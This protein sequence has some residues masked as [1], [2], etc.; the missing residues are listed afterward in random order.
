MNAETFKA[1]CQSFITAV[2]E[3]KLEEA[4]ALAFAHNYHP[5]MIHYVDEEDNFP[6]WLAVGNSSQAMVEFLVKECKCDVNQVMMKEQKQNVLHLACREGDTDMIYYL[7]KNTGVDINCMST[8]FATPICY[9][10]GNNTQEDFDLEILRYFLADL[11]AFVDYNDEDGRGVLDYLLI[12]GNLEGVKLYRQYHEISQ[13]ASACYFYMRPA[14]QSGNFELVKYLV[15]E[16]GMDILE[17]DDNNE[18]VLF[19]AAEAGDFEMIQYFGQPFHGRY[20]D[21]HHVNSNDD[22]ALHVAVHSNNVHIVQFLVERMGANIWVLDAMNDTPRHLAYGPE[23]AR[24]LDQLIYTRC[25]PPID[26]DLEKYPLPPVGTYQQYDPETGK[27]KQ[28][29]PGGAAAPAYIVV[30]EKNFLL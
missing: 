27:C 30:A 20:I 13:E 3:D 9:Y 15:E 17:P 23:I 25:P 22:T 19:H 28:V 26:F 24:Y 7:T 29:Y 21:V 18:T 4:R 1:A 5:E 16:V 12:D 6:L 10:V 11:N 8:C 14:I 2:A